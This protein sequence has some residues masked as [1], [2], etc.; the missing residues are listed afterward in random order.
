M[1]RAVIIDAPHAHVIAACLK[2]EADISVIETLPG[3]ETRVVLRNA[4]AAAI[5]TR[6][7]G[8]CVIT[9]AVKRTPLAPASRSVPMTQR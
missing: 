2:H 3:G 8:K 9:E 4:D 6:A 7:Y 1:S 5:I